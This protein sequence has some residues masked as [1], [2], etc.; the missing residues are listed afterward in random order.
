MCNSPAKK[1]YRQSTTTSQL[2]CLHG[3]L[4]SGLGSAFSPFGHAM[5]IQGQKFSGICSPWMRYDPHEAVM[6]RLLG[7]FVFGLL[8]LF[9]IFAIHCRHSYVHFLFALRTPLT[10]EDWISQCFFLVRHKASI[11]I[12]YWDGLWR[13][14]DSEG[15]RV[16]P[17]TQVRRWCC[18]LQHVL[19]Y[20][21]LGADQKLD[22]PVPCG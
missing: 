17:R 18:Q 12:P 8:N 15:L 16:R 21:G 9:L 7:P 14:R 2:L 22:R 1:V 20:Q 13:F 4:H 5:G 19:Q 10:Q 6:R 11:Q 3:V